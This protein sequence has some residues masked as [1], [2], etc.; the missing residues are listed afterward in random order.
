MSRISDFVDGFETFYKKFQE[1]YVS[2]LYF[3]LTG[4]FVLV[5]ALCA[6][7]AI[8]FENAP[9]RFVV[10]WC[11]LSYVLV[12]PASLIAAGRVPVALAFDLSW[13]APVY[14]PVAVIRMYVDYLT[15]RHVL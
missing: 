15:G 7:F 5:A 14:A 3:A 1:K 4:Y 12:A 11:A 2:R 10:V 9:A 8:G 13:L 6:L